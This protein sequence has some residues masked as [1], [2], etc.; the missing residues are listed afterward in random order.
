M[1]REKL[2]IKMDKGNRVE[3]NNYSAGFHRA[4]RASRSSISR[5]S[6]GFLLI[7]SFVLSSTVISVNAKCHF[8]CHI[9][10]TQR[11]RQELTFEMWLRWSDPV[12]QRAGK[13]VERMLRDIG[14]KVLLKPVTD[15][16]FRENFEN[17]HTFQMYIQGGGLSTY[18]VHLYERLHTNE[19][20]FLGT[21]NISYN[22]TNFDVLW[23]AIV[24]EDAIGRRLIS[25][26]EAQAAIDQD[27]PYIPLF[28]TDVVYTIRNEWIGF[29]PKQGGIFSELNRQT[30]INLSHIND[31]DADFIL[32]V[33]SFY[34]NY[35]PL[36]S[37][38]DLSRYLTSLI[39]DSLVSV[40]EGLE[41]IPWLAE[42]WTISDDGLSVTFDIIQGA[43]W[44]DGEPLTG[45]DVKFTLDLLKRNTNLTR[46]PLFNALE[47]VQL[48][49]DHSVTL[50]LE[51]PYAW[52]LN[53]L[54]KIPILPQHLWNERDTNW[55]LPLDESI[56]GSGPFIWN[57][58]ERREWIRLE[59]NSEYWMEG[60]PGLGSLTLKVYDLTKWRFQAILSGEADADFRELDLSFKAEAEADDGL[61]PLEETRCLSSR[62]YGMYFNLLFDPAITDV[63]FRKA[64]AYALDNQIIAEAVNPGFAIPSET[65]IQAEYFGNRYYDPI[66][67]TYERNIFLANQMLD[68]AGY[69]D[70]D[71]DGVREMPSKEAVQARELEEEG[72]ITTVVEPIDSSLIDELEGR[73]VR[74]DWIAG[75]SIIVAAVAVYLSLWK[76]G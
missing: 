38:D 28:T 29:N 21:N 12:S 1:K 75:I 68:K 24:E 54:A 50:N 42:E 55:S 44:H 52:T 62:D 9:A 41:I 37:H 11:T 23:E 32:A 33:P 43:R 15:V 66:V 18:P 58:N 64:I 59:A 7:L 76:R 47:G 31:T 67:N 20:R 25:L 30:T 6:I 61:V 5:A 72:I 13:E 53:D 36:L 60:K 57:S 73:I 34:V 3:E 46:P 4:S 69:L 40:G 8:T 14:I 10:D 65:Y 2:K 70:I 35:S 17:R 51:K 71:A 16:R 48:Q 39:F 26:W 27:L 19:L 74:S 45:E 22:N 63:V 56:I 49:G